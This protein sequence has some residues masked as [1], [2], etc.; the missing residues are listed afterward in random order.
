[1]PFPH[2]RGGIPVPG[3]V[4]I[5]AAHA[6]DALP[7][8]GGE[9]PGGGAVVQIPGRLLLPQ[10]HIHRNGVALI[11]PDLGVVL[12]EGVAPLVVLPDDAL[13]GGQVDAPSGPVHPGQQLIHIRPAVLIQSDP[14]RAGVVAQDQAQKPAQLYI[15]ITLI[16]RFL[17]N[18]P[19]R[20]PP[21]PGRWP[22]R[23]AG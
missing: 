6:P 19:R 17:L 3:E 1:M 16:H 8:D 9:E 18:M 15:R 23:S 14:R 4:D 12:A 13:Q 2:R 21:P 11:R 20:P 5:L 22:R 10:L 7:L